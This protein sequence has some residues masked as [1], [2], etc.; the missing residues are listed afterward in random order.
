[1][2]R[3]ICAILL[4]SLLLSGCAG[5]GEP[6]QKK[7]TATFLTLFD[8][9]TYIQGFADS[10]ESFSATAQSIHDELLKY[11]QL[12]DIYNDYEGLNNLKTVNDNAGIAPVT[13]DR[14]VIDL[15]LDC[16][17]YCAAT[18]GKVNAAMGS[19][20]Y[21]WHEARND[22]IND[23]AN[24]YLPDI[25]ALKN[26]AQ[27]ISF[28]AV[29]IDEAASTVFL[30]DPE[31]R[32]D[33]GAV[34]KGWSVQRVSENAPKGLLISVGGNVCATGPKDEA[35]TP[36]VVGVQ[37]PK[38]GDAYLNTLSVSS[39]SVVTSGDYQRGYLVDGELYHHIIDPDTLYPSRYWR[40]VTIVC[41]DSGLADA[42]STAL[43]VLSLEEG[44]ALLDKFE[45]RAMWVD[46]D[47][48]I[49]YS[50]GFEDLIRT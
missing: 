28:D 29:V 40:S 1:M 2:K 32:L 16:R 35:G 18:D 30:T 12:F 17:D 10:E 27:H 37:D 43:F 19:V 38:G 42:L 41:E 20:L 26:A 48:S 4:V 6:Q 49:F 34:A 25:D 24:A 39:G 46:A 23:P 22:G 14:A 3:L 44:Q 47:G 33:V 11:H 5:A 21:L 8:T 13:V 50:P 7:Y 15:L 36:W 31:M 9:V 45:A